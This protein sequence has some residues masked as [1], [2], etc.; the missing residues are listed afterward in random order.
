NT[1]IGPGRLW[2]TDNPD[3]SIEAFGGDAASPS[4]DRHIE[5]IRE[6]LDKVSG[7]PPLATGVVRAR[8][9]NLTSENALRITLTGLLSRTARKRVTYGRGLADL[10]SLILAALDQLGVFPTDPAAGERTV[11]VEWPDPIPQ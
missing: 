1:P 9:G 6:A 10:C 4:E 5:E 7:V 8:V 2:S 11:R 3:A